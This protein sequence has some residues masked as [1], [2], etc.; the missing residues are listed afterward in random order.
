MWVLFYLPP[1][2]P[3][4]PID[5]CWEKSSGPNSKHFCPVSFAVPLLQ[6]LPHLTAEHLWYPGNASH[7][8]ALSPQLHPDPSPGLARGLRHLIFLSHTNSTS[9]TTD[10]ATTGALWRAASPD[11]IANKS[12][13]LFVSSSFIWFR[14]LFSA[15]SASFFWRKISLARVEAALCSSSESVVASLPLPL[16]PYARSRYCKSKVWNSPFARPWDR[17]WDPWLY[18]PSRTRCRANLS[19]N[20]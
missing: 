10:T 9:P 5:S 2:S 15:S 17:T 7:K 19:K 8:T 13:V 20:Q 16:P 18:P 3:P 4:L 14:R 6:S 12:R 11:L 1:N